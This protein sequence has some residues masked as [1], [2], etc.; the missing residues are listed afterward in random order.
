MII[1]CLFCFV[2]ELLKTEDFFFFCRRRVV[3][4]VWEDDNK[5]LDSVFMLVSLPSPFLDTLEKSFTIGEIRI[6]H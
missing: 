6:T 3:V 4:C 1:D 5:W 2:V